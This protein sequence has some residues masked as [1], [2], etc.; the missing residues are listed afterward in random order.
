MKPLK[1]KMV[2]DIVKGRLCNGNG[3][4]E[5]V[6]AVHDSR[7]AKENNIFV[8]IKGERV[9]G[10]NYINSAVEGGCRAVFVDNE[11][12]LKNVEEDID[13]VLVDDTV[14]ALQKLAKWY[15]STLNAKK[16]AVT[17]STGKTSTRD[18]VYFVLS[19][20]FKTQKNE[21][22]FNSTIGVPLT[23][24][25]FDE[26]V[27]V[28]VLEMGMDHKGEIETMCDIAR[29][30][31]ACITN[32]GISHMENLGSQE[33]VF[34]AKMEVTSFF[35]E[36]NT[37]IV[38]HS[39]EFLNDKKIK[40]NFDLKV[41]GLGDYC[42]YVIENVKQ[43]E[44]MSISFTTVEKVTGE[45]FDFHVPLPGEHNAKNAT[46]AIAAGRK[47]G[48][49]FEEIQRGLSKVE[50]TGRRLSLIEKNGIKVIDDTYNASPDSMK[51]ALD[52]L[53]KT[54][55]KR[56]IAILGDMYELG[57]D[58]IK[59]HEEVGAV[60]KSKGHYTVTIGQLAKHMDG[61]RH[62]DTKD[63]FKKEM[64]GYFVEGDAVLLKASRGMAL[65]EVIETVLGEEQ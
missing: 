24:L 16:I 14:E 58:E 49:T 9:D 3:E 11:E 62:F 5:I 23:I 33:G 25:E 57:P 34:N 42:D 38:T 4:V 35:G 30:D 21:G 31:I 40:G 64:K 15:I 51:A 2:A 60:A 7:L 50:L 20:K 13:A 59:L 41:T 18:L 52:I 32:I 61:H 53:S 63:E 47:L 12:C 6:S 46:L 29:P 65:E 45:R 8:A 56:T 28:V 37:L 43:C 10:H 55:A 39:D 27:E 19:E 54:T 36:E 48:M 17:G 1:M 22:N 26:D 44:D